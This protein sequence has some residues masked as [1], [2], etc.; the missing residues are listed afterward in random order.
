MD[1]LATTRN[2]V[3]YMYERF[4]SP[5]LKECI[6]SFIFVHGIQISAQDV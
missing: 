4:K 1:N 5:L 2:K 3:C 6:S